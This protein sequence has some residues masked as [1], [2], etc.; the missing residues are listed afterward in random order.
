MA[1]AGRLILLCGLAG[2]GKTTLAK[3]LEADGAVR[4]CPDDWLVALGF[5]IYDKQARVSVE[6]LQWEL[7]ERSSS[8][9]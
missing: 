3:Q 4:M 6:G 1:L 5:D 2:A 7:S 9:G 8:E